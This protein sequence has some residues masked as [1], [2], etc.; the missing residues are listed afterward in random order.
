MLCYYCYSCPELPLVLVDFKL[1]GFPSILQHIFQGD[2]VLSN[3]IY[4][5]EG[6]RIFVVVVLTSLGRGK[7]RYTEECGIHHCV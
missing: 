1:E 6:I 4:V 7:V 3:D 5:K 2:Y